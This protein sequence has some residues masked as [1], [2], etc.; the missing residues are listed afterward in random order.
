MEQRKRIKTDDETASSSQERNKQVSFLDLPEEVFKEIC[1]FLDASTLFTLNQ[2]CTRFRTILYDFIVWKKKIRQIWPN[3]S[4]PILNPD[5][6]DIQFWKRSC[7]AIEKQKALYENAELVDCLTEIDTY[8]RKTSELFTNGRLL[9]MDNGTGYITVD[10][11][12]L[13]YKKFGLLKESYEIYSGHTDW[14]F[15][16]T[17]RKNIIY[18][19]SNEENIKSWEIAEVGLKQQMTHKI[20]LDM[21]S[22]CPILLSSCSEHT[23]FAVGS[24][25]GNIFVLDSREKNSIMQYQPSNEI[26]SITTLTM[27]SEYILSSYLNKISVYEQKATKVMKIIPMPSN[28]AYMNM[29]QDCVWVG[30]ENNKLHVLDPKKDFELVKS[31]S[32]G[33]TRRITGVCLTHGKLITSS[34]DG[35]VRISSPTNPPQHINCFNFETFLPNQQITNMDYK[36]G[37]L[38]ICDYKKIIIYQSNYSRKD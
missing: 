1:L 19:C 9:L 11:Q 12:N 22:D 17:M 4:Y 2:V 28:V 20:K 36:N 13:I 31:Y 37:V 25:F 5:D 6:R 35:T 24:L 21:L 8:E 15:D 32:I 29:Q 38:G 30:D 14:I 34:T 23:R 10:G 3:V 18:S 16:L 26:A 33:H 7:L 27:N